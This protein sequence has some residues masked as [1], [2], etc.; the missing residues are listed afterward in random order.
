M[1]SVEYLKELI[2]LLKASGVVFFK[3]GQ[4]EIGLAPPEKEVPHPQTQPEA[5]P[6]APNLKADDLF[7]HDRILHWS[8]S[9]DLDPLPLT[10][11]ETLAAP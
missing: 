6:S 7:N 4:L 10:G 2:P 9:G 3:E 5:P 8:G 1:A 11:E